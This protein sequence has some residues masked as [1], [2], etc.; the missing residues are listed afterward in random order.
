MQMTLGD[1]LKK[2]ILNPDYRFIVNSAHGCYKSMSDEEYLKRMF[3]AKMG[4]QLNLENPKTYN[5]K[6]QWLKLYDRR[7][8]YVSLVDKYAVKKFV[9]EQIGDQY[10]IPTLG[11]WQRFEDIDFTTL[12]NQFVLKCTHDSGGL[13]ICRDKTA[14]D[15]NAARVKIKKSMKRNYYYYGREW[16][17]KNVLPRIICEK[18][19][20]DESQMEKDSTYTNLEFCSTQK[21]QTNNISEENLTDYKFYC[22]DGEIK[23]VGIYTDRQKASETCADYYN[24]NFEWINMEWGYPHAKYRPVKPVQFE[25]MISIAEKLSKNIPEIRVDLYLCGEKVYFGELTFYD[26]SGFDEIKTT[27]KDIEWGEWIK[28]PPQ[29]RYNFSNR[30]E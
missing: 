16:P 1:K 25:E 22:F 2:Y 8:E 27:S 11:V 21:R 24:R 23:A 14:F 15:I 6:L 3:K 7:H 18:Y 26:G 20:T 10:V 28:L 29:N 5:E 17:Y 19:M 9:S 4:Y 13:V 12:P 30:G